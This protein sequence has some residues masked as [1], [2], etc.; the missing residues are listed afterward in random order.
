M[1]FETRAD[2]QNL[3]LFFQ[4]EWAR[5]FACSGIAPGLSQKADPR[6]QWQA[7]LAARIESGSE[8]AN[9]LCGL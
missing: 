2:E 8:L 7:I 1:A 3:S 4:T 5:S 9:S 6:I